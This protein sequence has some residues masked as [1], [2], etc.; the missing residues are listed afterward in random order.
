MSY[1][2]QVFLRN[3]SFSEEY[4]QEKYAGKDA[5]E[6]I[7]HEWEDEFRLTE[8]VE[9]VEIVRDESYLLS[10]E[11]GEGQPFAFEIQDVVQF[12]FHHV[13]GTTVLVFSE[14]CLDEYKLDHDAKRLVVYLNDQE[15]VENP[16][17]GIYLVLS[18][19]PKELRQ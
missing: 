14:A 6:N 7:R 11:S 13:E 8:P 17:P 4:A 3:G 2:I 9:V 19:F 12:L 18:S 5:P 15:V 10:G 1:T 16:I